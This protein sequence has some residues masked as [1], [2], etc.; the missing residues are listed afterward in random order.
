M[1]RFASG[2]SRLGERWRK[3]ANRAVF[4]GYPS[5]R[6]HRCF[7]GLIQLSSSQCLRINVIP[8]LVPHTRFLVG[9]SLT[10]HATRR[11][12]HG[13]SRVVQALSAWSVTTRH[14]PFRYCRDA[15]VYVYSHTTTTTHD[16]AYTTAALLPDPT[17]AVPPPFVIEYTYGLLCHFQRPSTCPR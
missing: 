14:T 2:S 8:D 11:T 15:R 5:R 6:C 9:L 13:A 4:F 3:P 12:P 7:C 16:N 10:L 1:L 17:R